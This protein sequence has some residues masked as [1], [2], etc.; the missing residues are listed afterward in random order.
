MIKSKCW[1]KTDH[2]P[3]NCDYITRGKWYF[4]TMEED[5]V[6]WKDDNGEDRWSYLYKT[7]HLNHKDWQVH[8][9]ETPPDCNTQPTIL[10]CST[11]NDKGLGNSE[12]ASSASLPV[13]EVQDV[14]EEA[15]L[16]LELVPI[17][18]D[19]SCSSL[20]YV[21]YQTLLDKLK[22]GEYSVIHNTNIN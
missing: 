22:S 11:S 21:K 7:F 12:V 17:Y 2:V 9:G 14:T 20:N 13:N 3:N 4:A 19:F 1:I 10:E 6:T 16:V 8:Y 18:S 15:L 5:G